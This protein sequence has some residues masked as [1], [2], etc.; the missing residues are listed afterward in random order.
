MSLKPSS[1]SVN[2]LKTEPLEDVIEAHTV[3][4]TP[5]E[6]QKK[7]GHDIVLNQPGY[8]MNG[9]QLPVQVERV[10]E[11][12]VHSRSAV[13]KHGGEADLPS[14]GSMQVLFSGAPS[15]SVRVVG[16]HIFPEVSYP[17]DSEVKHDDATDST[18]LLQSF[19]AATIHKQSIGGYSESGVETGYHV[20]EM[21]DVEVP[22]MLNAQGAEPGS[23]SFNHF[24]ELPRADNLTTDPQYDESS[25]E[26][27]EFTRNKEMMQSNPERIGIRF[28]DMALIYDRLIEFQD[29][30]EAFQQSPERITILNNQSSGDLYARLFSTFLT[31]PGYAGANLDPT[32]LQVQ[33]L[34]IL[35]VLNLK[36]IWY[37]FSLVEWRIRLGQVL[38]SNPEPVPEHSAQPLWT[39]RDILLLQISLSCE[40]LLRLDA[41]TVTMAGEVEDRADVSAQEMEAFRTLISRKIDWD[42]ILARRFL[43]NI[44][45]IKGNDDGTSVVVPESRGLFSILSGST[46]KKFP[47][48]DVIFLPQHQSRQLLGLFRFAEL[49][50]WPNIDSIVKSLTEK[51]GVPDQHAESTTQPSSPGEWSFNPIT[52]SA[53][54]V[55]GTPLQTPRSANHQLDDY[56]GRI[57]KPA[58]RRNNSR[59][60]RVPLSKTVSYIER[61]PE[62]AVV[63]IGGWLSRSLLSGMVLP[64]EALSHF[65]IS[66][67]LENDQLAISVL[68]DSANLYGG[69]IY[70]GKTWWSK[71][72]IVG[73]VLACTDGAQECM[74]WIYLDK[75]PEGALEGWH[76]VHSEQVPL[77]SRSSADE[78]LV[79]ADS[80]VL[81]VGMGASVESK[82][83]I[84]PKDLEEVP[85]R[86]VSFLQWDLT[87][88][89]P[90][91][92]DNETEI[93][94][95]TESDTHAPSITFKVDSSLQDC[96]LTLTYEVHFVTSWPCYNPAPTSAASSRYAAKRSRAGTLSH[97]SSKRSVST[98]L[99]RHNSHGFEPLLSHPPES[100]GIGPQRSYSAGLDGGQ[101]SSSAMIGP[102][103]AHPVHVSY[104]YKT[105]PATELLDPSF[106]LPF[107]VAANKL[108]TCSSSTLLRDG[109]I[110]GTDLS[111]HK[112]VLVVDARGET[113]LQL[114]ARA[115]CAEK[116]FHAVIGRVK[117]SCL[118]CC[119][120]DA[121]GV[122]INMVI[123]V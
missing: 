25:E 104:K 69:F 97:T 123:R 103:I 111:D 72:S 7:E 95:P 87:P 3:T 85:K 18:P 77:I 16:D 9:P 42:L 23:I 48:S 15:F 64:G 106:I 79:A 57:Q 100:V 45:V 108:P 101:P 47:R 66:T 83:L 52:P 117:R 93:G 65:L 92:I 76:S 75:L 27:L 94:P 122:G 50:K 96:V 109:N 68:G 13:E 20:Y 80:Y 6:G 74:G 8:S 26:F 84:M 60:L 46:P 110:D 38:F 37:N 121:R 12:H 78:D 61:G 4:I 107:A 56:F 62:S 113:D 71:A 58:M 41:I 63:N 120:R 31:P 98:K 53:V 30:Y 89:N 115:W 82:D 49:I 39:E 102:V 28:V 54:S 32:G 24:V 119:I 43:E 17:W 35:N 114:L 67:L 90:D 40:L 73:R 88:L 22:N 5:V 99:S 116:G 112:T 33:I 1:S 44:L 10:N 36:G 2:A 21:D 86:S 34:A 19:M 91:L 118:A 55:Y 29:L 81:P 11:S 70:N 14:E 51:L 59:L 105:V